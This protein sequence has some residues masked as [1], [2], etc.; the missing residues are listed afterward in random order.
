[1]GFLPAVVAVA[2]VNY[3]GR[4]QPNCRQPWRSRTRRRASVL[5]G[6]CARRA[7]GESDADAVPDLAVPLPSSIVNASPATSAHLSLTNCSMRWPPAWPLPSREGVGDGWGSSAAE[8]VSQFPGPPLED[9]PTSPPRDSTGALLGGARWD[10]WRTRCPVFAAMQRRGRCASLP[11]AAV[12]A[13]TTAQPARSG[14]S[15]ADVTP[16]EPKVRDWRG[17]R[18]GPI[19]S[20]HSAARHRAWRVTDPRAREWAAV[21]IHAGTAGLTW[22]FGIAMKAPP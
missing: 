2:G 13:K 14:A 9:P 12:A 8:A 6:R 3:P 19:T 7:A 4:R 21:V 5:P 22:Q 1:M 15:A 10:D 20:S 11:G 17:G 16:S 18:A